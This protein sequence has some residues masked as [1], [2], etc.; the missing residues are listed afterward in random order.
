MDSADSAKIRIEFFHDTICS[1][2]FPM[3]CRMRQLQEKMPHVEIAHRSFALAVS[4]EVY[5]LLYGSH[6]R[7]K[8]EILEHWA[9]AN[10]NDE[11]RRFNIEGMKKQA[12]NYPTSM[13]ALCA[14]KA[15]GFVAGEGAHWDA[16]DA[17]QRAFFVE[18]RNIADDDVI[19]DVVGSLPIDFD[20]WRGHYLSDGPEKAVRRDCDLAKQHGIKSVPAL[21]VNGTRV[22]AGT[23]PLDGLIGQVE[24]ARRDMQN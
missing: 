11:L 7:A 17:L 21:L 18:S 24:E 1:F 23:Q 4:A 9:S 8:D 6:Q 12:F 3:S 15:V 2:C 16:F 20:A 13:P 10:E 22:I 14:C 19:A 5:P